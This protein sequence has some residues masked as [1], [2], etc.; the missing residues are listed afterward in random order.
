VIYLLFIFLLE[1]AYP[2][3]VGKTC[4]AK[5]AEIQKNAELLLEEVSRKESVRQ[6]QPGKLYIKTLREGDGLRPISP[7]DVPT[8]RY[9][10]YVM[11]G[12][13]D[14]AS[15]AIGRFSIRNTN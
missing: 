10:D 4:R 6:I 15:R 11:E 14:V 1:F 13:E 7:Y 9:N 8:I 3:S 12:E 2:F 5:L